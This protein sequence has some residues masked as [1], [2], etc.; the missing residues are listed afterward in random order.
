MHHLELRLE[1]PQELVGGHQSSA[2]G[3]L[4]ILS[5]LC[6][7]E[8]WKYG[9]R[10]LRSCHLNLGHMLQALS[11][12]CELH[13][14][15]MEE[16]SGA[17]ILDPVLRRILDVQDETPELALWV[18]TGSEGSVPAMAWAEELMAVYQQAHLKSLGDPSPLSATPGTIYPAWPVMDAAQEALKL[19]RE[20]LALL[21]GAGAEASQP[22]GRCL[23]HLGA[24]LLP[25]VLRRRSALGFVT[26]QYPQEEF[27]RMLSASC[28]CAM[29]PQLLRAGSRMKIHLLLMLHDVEGFQPGLY[30]LQR[31]RD[32]MLP[33]FVEPPLMEVLA[34]QGCTLWRLAA[35]DV[36]HA[37]QLSACGQDIAT[38]GSFAAAFVGNFH[39]WTHPRNYAEL[40]W[41]SGALGQV[42]Y[43]AAEAA[44]F[45]AT[46]MG[47][48]MDDITLALLR[49]PWA[50][51]SK[52]KN[53]SQSFAPMESQYQVLYHFAVGKPSVDPRLLSFEA[54]QHLQDG[55]YYEALQGGMGRIVQASPVGEKMPVAG[56]QWGL[57]GVLLAGDAV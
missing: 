15:I 44:G 23:H 24:Q 10:A 47:C 29:E 55:F 30:L 9:E 53:D 51:E 52:A 13:G 42:L 28:E 6:V 39:G 16:A 20:D 32:E 56:L 12:S 14:W 19:Q 34:L 2:S 46:G 1:A 41:Q 57:V 36:H 22:R 21:D 4:V 27:V 40:L 31:A 38:K 45:G 50:M 3:F 8:A 49:S 37:A 54:Y 35:A 26:E 7:R 43:L 25:S 48:F 11:V 17:L 5:S 33:G 18:T